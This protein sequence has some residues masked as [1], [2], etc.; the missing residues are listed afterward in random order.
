VCNITKYILYTVISE[1]VILY[2]TIS[3]QCKV[4]QRLHENLL[5]IQRVSNPSTEIQRISTPAHPNWLVWSEWYKSS[6]RVYTGPK[7][8]IQGVCRAEYHNVSVIVTNDI[9]KVYQYDKS[10]GFVI[11][12]FICAMTHSYVPWFKKI[13]RDLR[14]KCRRMKRSLGD[15]LHES[16]KCLGM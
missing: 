12:W 1:F 10:L 14:G 16:K 8:R 2:G 11:M 4:S 13:N 7:T 6:R 9:T 15:L 5:G 3:L